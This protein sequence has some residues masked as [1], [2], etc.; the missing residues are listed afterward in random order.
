M[1]MIDK[2]KDI[3]I[4][5]HYFI[6][7]LF[8][9][10]LYKISTNSGGFLNIG[11]I[12]MP[13][14]SVFMACLLTFITRLINEVIN[15]ILVWIITV[16]LCIIFATQYVFIFLF[17]VPFSFR[18]ISLANQA[19]DFMDIALKAIYNNVFIVI[20]YFVP[21]I[22]LAI[23]RKK[24]KYNRIDNQKKIIYLS[25]CIGLHL[26]AILSLLPN[27]S[28]LYSPY[29]LYYNLD[30]PSTTY[31]YF[32]VLTGMR[33]DVKGLIFK[34]DKDFIDIVIPELEDNKEDEETPKEPIEYGYNI[35]D[36]DFNSLIEGTSD[37]TTKQ[38]HTYFSKEQPTRQNEYT[39]IF[40]D[41]NLIFIVAEGFNQ[42]AVR[43]DLTP[44]LYKLSNESFVFENFYTPTLFS[45]V[46]GEMQALVGVLPFQE[47]VNLWATERPTFPYAIGNSFQKE[48]YSAKAYHNWT[49]TYYNRD[50]TR[51]TIGFSDFLGKGNGLEKLMNCNTWPTS[52]V[53]LIEAISEQIIGQESKMVTYILTVS[54]HANYGW[55]GNYI[56]NKNKSLVE[57]LSYSEEVKGYL[58]AQIELDR[59]LEL[60]I[61]NLEEAGE[62]EDTVIA[63][64]G[65]HYPYYFTLDQI[66]EISTYKR[67][68]VEV[69]HSNFILYNSGMERVVIDKVSEQIDVLPTLLNLFGIP[70]DSRLIIGKDILS[71][72]EGLAIFSE[73]S[74]ITDLGRYDNGK[75]IPKEGV[76]I[77]EGYVDRMRQIIANKFTMSK[78]IFK[79]NYYM[80][81]LK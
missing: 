37:N 24:V 46:G 27:R 81:V 57:H 47:T 29:K 32:G 54:G 33:L 11:L 80:E 17:A 38:M 56:S 31:S 51:P 72:T 8:L 21:I 55:G 1:E 68:K 76:E 52:D 25:V 18:S 44:T 4:F 20:L 6:V 61:K 65:D 7:I 10:L 79:K 28:N 59:A 69:N 34:T 3:G 12:Y 39:G 77:P 43:E 14:F 78:L 45:T 49:Y 36:I 73:S 67:D 64:V 16:L 70:F 60:L 35:A 74:W 50:K 58:A 22:F 9:E 63:L 75:F 40:K 41:K 19:L 66:N 53:D 42:I 30:M 5:L 62:L 48:G 2:E 13:L 23:I 15:K 71:E 26:I